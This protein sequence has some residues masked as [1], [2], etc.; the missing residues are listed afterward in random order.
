MPIEREIE[1][2]AYIII[3][4]SQEWMVL[5]GPLTMDASV[6]HVLEYMNK[7]K[8]THNYRV[9]FFLDGRSKGRARALSIHSNAI[10]VSL[11]VVFMH[12]RI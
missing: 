3:A 8:W 11:R 10:W 6:G 4:I 2:R 5:E 1:K 12:T 9:S 7:S